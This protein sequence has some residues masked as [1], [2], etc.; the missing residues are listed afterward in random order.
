[1]TNHQLIDT[2]VNHNDDLIDYISH[3]FGDR[4][5][6][7]DVVQETCIRILQTSASLDEI[8]TPIALLRKICMRVAIDFYRKDK[9]FHDW[10]D[11]CEEP[12]DWIDNVNNQL[13]QPEL[14]TAK[15]QRTQI[16]LKAIETLPIHCRA[17][18]IL[19][20]L[21]HQSQH[22]VAEQLQL[23]RGMVARYLAQAFKLIQ[24]V[25]LDQDE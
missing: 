22:Q 16:L 1:M 19:T 21:Y 20:Q 6:A 13:T 3:R 17:V 7:Q 2:L 12:Q 10:I 4:Q 18:F 25:V 11:I 24:P 14:I 9:T 5:F 8:H 23:S 15:Q